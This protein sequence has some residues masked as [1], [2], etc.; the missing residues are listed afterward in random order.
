MGVN[1]VFFLNNGILIMLVKEEV[2][3]FVLGFV[4]VMCLIE[5]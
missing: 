5:V 1:I 3:E 2:I 4:V